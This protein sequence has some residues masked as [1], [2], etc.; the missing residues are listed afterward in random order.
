MHAAHAAV[1]ATEVFGLRPLM[2][3]V[4]QCLDGIFGDGLVPRSKWGPSSLRILRPHI[5]LPLWLGRRP[6]DGKVL[7]Y[8]L[9]NRVV[10]PPEAGYSVRITYALDFRGRRMTYDSH[11]GTDFAVPPGTV[12][13]AP[14]AGVVRVVAKQM[15]RGGLQVLIDHGDGLACTLAHLS[16]ALVRPGQSVARGEPVALSGMS[17]V[18]GVLFFPWL[19][20]HVHMNVLLDGV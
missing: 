12:V 13:V 7:I 20:P 16:R 11:V 15:Q 17:G 10:A 1:R 3:A 19:A 4:R 14:A 6:P 2:P 9:P 5:S 18:D 8:Q